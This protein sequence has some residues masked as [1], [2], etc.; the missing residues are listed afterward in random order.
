MNRYNLPEFNAVRSAFV[1]MA[2]ALA[3]GRAPIIEGA[4]HLCNTGRTLGID[5]RDVDFRTIIACVSETDALPAGPER[6]HWDAAALEA[7][8]GE[9]ADA[10]ARW[11]DEVRAASGRLADRFAQS[12]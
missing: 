7:K 4:R 11:A 2:H 10:E 6:R 9:I 12:V 5:A 8:A 1:M 3:A